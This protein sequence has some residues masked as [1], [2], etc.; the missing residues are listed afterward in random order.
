MNP[1]PGEKEEAVEKRCWG[2]GMQNPTTEFSCLESRQDD[3]SQGNWHAG[4]GEG[5]CV[6]SLCMCWLDLKQPQWCSQVPQG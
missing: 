2:E 6:L 1:L 5:L 3:G 4:R